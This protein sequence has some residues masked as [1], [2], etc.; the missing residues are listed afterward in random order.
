MLTAFLLPAA[1]IL[2]TAQPAGATVSGCTSYAFHVGPTGYDT[3]DETGLSSCPGYDL[4]ATLAS[5]AADY[6]GWYYS[7][8]GWQEGSRGYVP[9]P[10]NSSNVV[11]VSDC[12]ECYQHAQSE[13][14]AGYVTIEL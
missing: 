3:G 7:S 8:S 11:L 14:V 12:Y 1:A 5:P 6:R 9:V 13:N 2:S 10:D 4:Y